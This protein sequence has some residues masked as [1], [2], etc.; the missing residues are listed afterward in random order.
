MKKS[1]CYY[2]TK[3]FQGFVLS[4]DFD[5]TQCSSETRVFCF[6]FKF[7]FFGCWINVYKI[8]K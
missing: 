6:T 1:S 4:F 8:L 3:K 7:V 2:F 5:C